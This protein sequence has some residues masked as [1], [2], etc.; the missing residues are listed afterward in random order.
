MAKPD[1]AKYG[2]LAPMRH[3]LPVLGIALGLMLGGS[4]ACADEAPPISQ[5]PQDVAHLAMVW[6]AVPE[7]VYRVAHDEGP[8]AGVAKGSV[9][10]GTRMVSDAVTYL[11]SGYVHGSR[12]RA[13]PIGSLV[14][15]SF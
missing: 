1:G 2:T 11:T 10:G 9:E 4:V 13:R 15:Y 8:V 3:L 14:N 6:V 5:L 7:A 12:P